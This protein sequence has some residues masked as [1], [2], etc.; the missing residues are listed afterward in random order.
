MGAAIVDGRVSPDQ[1]I[2]H[3]KTNRLTSIRI[4]DKKFMV[5]ATISE[6]QKSRLIEVPATLRRKE[7]LSDEQVE[8]ISRLALKSE[9]HFGCAQDI[10]WSIA[11]DELF[12][13]QSRPV[14]VMGAIED[15]VPAGRYILFKPL[16]E[17]FTDPLMPLTVD[18]ELYRSIDA[19]YGRYPAEANTSNGYY[20]RSIV[21]E[22]QTD[23]FTD[24]SQAIRR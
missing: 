19:A 12:F 16:V 3:K 1:Y 10:E 11:G 8:E 14:T 23:T 21:C 7:S 18:I 4:S 22:L 6:G 24:P 5:P 13:L 9:A 20:L 17:N 2:V 15:D